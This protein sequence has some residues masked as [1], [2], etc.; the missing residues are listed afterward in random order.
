MPARGGAPPCG[1]INYMGNL[2]VQE[3]PEQHVNLSR[4]PPVPKEVP[5]LSAGYPLAAVA[6]YFH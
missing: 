5:N 1:I 2:I 6:D 3:R 4:S